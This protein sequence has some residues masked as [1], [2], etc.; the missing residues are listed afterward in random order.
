MKQ[1]LVS[2][3]ELSIL[4]GRSEHSLRFHIRKGRITPAAKFGRSYSFDPDEV[5]RQLQK[6][7][8][9]SL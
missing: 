1:K 7:V 4:L 2:L 5:L 6:G 3:K 9:R 8:K